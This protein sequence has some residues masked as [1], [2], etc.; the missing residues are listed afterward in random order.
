M[1]LPGTLRI[2]AVALAF[3]VVLMSTADA[4]SPRALSYLAARNDYT[5]SKLSLAAARKQTGLHGKVV[6]WSGVVQGMASSD[7]G[8][9]MFLRV[10]K[11]TIPVRMSSSSSVALG[12]PV[13]VLGRIKTKSGLISYLEPIRLAPCGEVRKA[14]VAVQQQFEEAREAEKRYREARRQRGVG[15]P[16]AAVLASRFGGNVNGGSI[17]L[18]SAVQ[19]IR[20]FNRS[21][22][23][24]SAESIARTVLYY[25]NSYGVDPRLAL[26][27]L[28]AESAF[29]PDAVSSAGAQGLGQLMPG[30]AD[31]LGVRDPFDPHQNAEGA[32]R[33][34]G[35]LLAMW[36]TTSSPVDL[37]LAS[38]N[39]GPGAVEQYGGI[40]PYNETIN[41]VKIIRGYY[42][43]LK[44][45]R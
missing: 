38:Y 10:G 41:Y 1:L 8:L 29:R 18:V 33:H 3:V 17:S 23:N 9:F 35:D 28:A 12:T 36:K 21:L 16:P 5:I 32:I 30:T 22:D 4:S 11:D 44:G 19:W 13:Y 39:A 6:E 45:Y 24:K 31:M 34:L 40:P 7:D 25:S 20:E 26:S 42:G 15:A 27:L 2:L 37:A 43:E 14:Y